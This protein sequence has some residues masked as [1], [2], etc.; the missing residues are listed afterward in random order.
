MT[1]SPPL[2]V[3]YSSLPDSPIQVAYENA[4][5]SMLDMAHTTPQRKM[6]KP[7][8]P[9]GQK[10]KRHVNES[11]RAKTSN[12]PGKTSAPVSYPE[13]PVR[14]KD[15]ISNVSDIATETEALQTDSLDP[16]EEFNWEW[17]GLTQIAPETNPI[18]G[19][20][21]FVD[22]VLSEDCPFFQLN[23]N[24]FVVNGWNHKKKEASVCESKIGAT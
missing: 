9:Q 11:S 5:Y 24:I 15:K 17:E 3:A 10:R 18:D 8:Q 21:A 16:D 20:S 6:R 12:I 7:Y 13:S 22:A 23:R 19:Y 2:Q 14:L 1:D 4:E